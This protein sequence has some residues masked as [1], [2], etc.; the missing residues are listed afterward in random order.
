MHQQFGPGLERPFL[1]V[2]AIAFFGGAVLAMAGT[3]RMIYAM[4]RDDRFPAHRVFKR[5]NPHTHTPIQATL[6]QLGLGIALITGMSDGVMMQL[7]LAG[8]II[9]N[10]PYG[11]TVALYL[12]VRGK[13]ERTDGAFNLGRFEL[14][15]AVAAILW[16]LFAAF[17]SIV[18]SPSIVPILIV[19]GMLLIGGVYLAYLL[20][21]RRHVLEHEPGQADRATDAEDDQVTAPAAV[22][23]PRQETSSMALASC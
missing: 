20:M 11:M 19:V 12:A 18:T 2:I 5:V 3:S 13:L 6:L 23:C 14:P 21:F 15:V 8:A 1:V 10:I 22:D 17:V 16:L 4:A 9:V 7:I